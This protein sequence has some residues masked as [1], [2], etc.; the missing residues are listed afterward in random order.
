[1]EWVVSFVAGKERATRRIFAPNTLVLSCDFYQCL[2]HI[3]K[4]SGICTHNIYMLYCPGSCQMN[5]SD[6][7]EC[8][9][10]GHSDFYLHKKW[11]DAVSLHLICAT[12]ACLLHWLLLGNLIISTAQSVQSL[13]IHRC[14]GNQHEV[15][16]TDSTQWQETKKQSNL[17]KE[18]SHPPQAKNM[19]FSHSFF[20]ML[21]IKG[22][23]D[24]I[25]R[26]IAKDL[27]KGIN[28]I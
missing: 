11:I 6:A 25:L 7:N 2:L 22:H 17:K 15:P 18:H 27:W 4:K 24:T 9:I 20:K 26:S 16:E 21:Q 8:A 10:L 5:P 19:I 1:M 3:M 14:L 13:L 23:N 28:K 12:C